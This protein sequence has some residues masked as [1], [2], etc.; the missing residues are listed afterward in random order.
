MRPVAIV[1]RSRSRSCERGLEL[2]VL[3]EDRLGFDHALEHRLALALE[4][5][6]LAGGIPIIA[7][8]G[9]EA[10]RRWRSLREGRRKSGR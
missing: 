2:L 3:L 10:A 7:R 5:A 4:L 8:A 6:V 9:D 1:V